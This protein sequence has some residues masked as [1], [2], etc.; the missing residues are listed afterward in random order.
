MRFYFQLLVSFLLVGLL[1]SCS[2]KQTE[3]Q[4]VST[5]QKSESENSKGELFGTLSESVFTIRTFEGNRILE[6]GRCFAVAPNVLVAPFSFFNEATR[7]EITPF[8][9]GKTLQVHSFYTFDRIEN[10]ILIHCDSLNV[11]PLDFYSG[12][13]KPLI[14]TLLIGKRASKTIPL[15][16]GKFLEDAVVQGQQLFR[17]SNKVESSNIGMPVFLSNGSVLGLATMQYVSSKP[18]SFAI[19]AKRIS[20]LLAQLKQPQSFSKLSEERSNFYKRVKSIQ[21]QTDKGTISIRLY[22]ETP[23][24]RDNFL[25]LAHEGFYDSLLFHRIIRDFGI[26]TGAADSRNAL[27]DDVVGWKGPGYTLPA[28]IVDGLFHKRGA[29]GS[30]RKPDTQNSKRRSDGSQFYIVTGRKYTDEELDEL[31]QENSIKFTQNQRETYKSIGGSPHLDGQY[32]VFGEVVSGLEVA[33]KMVN[34]ATRNDYRPI[35]DIRLKRVVLVE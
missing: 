15:H 20:S 10:L 23:S 3:K 25:A 9:G 8:Q 5:T 13:L 26:Q 6:T 14:Q 27:P 34:V 29:I 24:Y 32:T 22:N 19:P 12:E 30:P 17:I 2:K 18:T 21:L 33:D 4:E 35:N 31:E 11:K 28:H 7:A 16:A 1:F